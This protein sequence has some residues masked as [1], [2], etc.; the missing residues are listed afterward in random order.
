MFEILM[1]F[2]VVGFIVN[3]L[4]AC[5]AIGKADTELKKLMKELEKGE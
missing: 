4:K 1:T 2:L 3:L 5:Y